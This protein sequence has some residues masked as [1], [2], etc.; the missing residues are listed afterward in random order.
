M[1]TQQEKC[2]CGG[3]E[4][5]ENDKKLYLVESVAQDTGERFIKYYLAHGLDHLEDEI[6]DI[7]QI[8]PLTNFEDLT[9]A[10]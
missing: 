7:V 10:D 1:N 2:D 5:E 9:L 8:Q 3:E 6:A 4:L